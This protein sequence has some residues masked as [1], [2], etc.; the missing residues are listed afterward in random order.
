M[1]AAVT[2]E[3]LTVDGMVLSDSVYLYDLNN[4]SSYVFY[5]NEKSL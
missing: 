1:M 5:G 4:T 3:Q 2:Y